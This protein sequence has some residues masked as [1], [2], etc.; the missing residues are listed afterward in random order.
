MSAKDHGYLHGR[1]ADII[2]A[3][4]SDPG[5]NSRNEIDAALKLELEL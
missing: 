5:D 1:A 4:H 3:Y 2:A